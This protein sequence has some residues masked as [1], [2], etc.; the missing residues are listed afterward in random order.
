[1][2]HYPIIIIDDDA[3]DCEFLVTAFKNAGVKNE[4]KCFNSPTQ[5]LEQLSSTLHNIFIIIC[6]INMPFLNGFELRKSINENAILARRATPFIFLS[7][8][9]SID[10]ISKAK[11][12]CVQGFFQKPS[13][14]N[15]FHTLAKSITEYWNFNK[16]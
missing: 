16:I 11:Q 3:D 8:T 4:L 15:T 14:M 6:D 1:M 9:A 13:D 10:Q 7:T 12:L 2:N 5:A